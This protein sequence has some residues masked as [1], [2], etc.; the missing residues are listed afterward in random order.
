MSKILFTLTIKTDPTKESRDDRIERARIE[1]ES[2]VMLHKVEKNR[3]KYSR[4]A[5]YKEGSRA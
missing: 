2:G 5:K 1:M 4:K 3:K